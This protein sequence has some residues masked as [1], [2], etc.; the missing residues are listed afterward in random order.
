MNP[1]EHLLQERRDIMA[2]VADLRAGAC[3][4]RS[5]RVRDLEARGDT[6]LTDALPVLRR[7]GRMMEAQLALHARKEDEALTDAAAGR[8][9][10]AVQ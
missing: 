9:M 6:A 1:T 2:Q 4:E 3:P 7:I 5:R 8:R 10:E